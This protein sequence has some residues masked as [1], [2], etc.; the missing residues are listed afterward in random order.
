MTM[1]PNSVIM[2]M[3]KTFIINPRYKNWRDSM[4]IRPSTAAEHAG[5]NSPWPFKAPRAPLELVL[6]SSTCMTIR[7][8]IDNDM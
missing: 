1:I 7:Y 2:I 6:Y 4:I 3:N 5:L 8:S